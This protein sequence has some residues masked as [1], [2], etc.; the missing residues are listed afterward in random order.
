MAAEDAFIQSQ[1][2]NETVGEGQPLM[3]QRN[4]FGEVVREYTA[5]ASGRVAIRGTDAIREP[6]SDILTDS[7]NCPPEG[8]P[9]YGGEE[10]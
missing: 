6:D 1:P 2:I 4:A 9:Y 10:R 7:P 8:C 5:A 3:I